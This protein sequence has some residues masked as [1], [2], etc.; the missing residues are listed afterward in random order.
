MDTGSYILGLDLG[1]MAD[2]AA[3]T[4]LE[5]C[6]DRLLVRALKRWPLG[7]PYTSVCDDVRARLASPALAG[8]HVTLAIDATGVGSAVW[9]ILRRNPPA[10]E[11]VGIVITSGRKAAPDPRDPRVWHVPKAQL[12]E[13]LTVAITSGRLEI[14]ARMAGADVLAGELRDFEV[15]MTKAGRETWGA[16][17][18][19]HD[20][21]LL[22]LSYTLWLAALRAH[23][24]RRSA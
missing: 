20:D 4:L 23:G 18:G 19:R 3:A 24:L 9:D 1:K 14:A 2:Y 6:G 21:V 15:H 17:S 10:C 7:T 12:V 13:A 22:S 11:L 16:R 8:A 5:P